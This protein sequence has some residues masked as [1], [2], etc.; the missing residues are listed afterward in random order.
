MKIH[1]AFFQKKEMIAYTDHEGW[2]RIASCFNN[3]NKKFASFEELQKNYKS[4]ANIEELALINYALSFK[5]FVGQFEDGTKEANCIAQEIETWR[6]LKPLY[7]NIL[8]T[9]KRIFDKLSTTKNN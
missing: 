3:I 9:Q 5:E 4:F 7:K 6:R 2:W 1:R 8:D